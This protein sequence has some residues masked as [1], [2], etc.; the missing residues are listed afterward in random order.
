MEILPLDRSDDAVLEQLWRSTQRSERV[1][2]MSGVRVS[3]A[4]FAEMAR[5]AHPGERDEAVVALVDGRVVGGGRIWFPERDNLTLSWLEVHVDPD[6]RRRGIGSALL[7]DLESR[8]RAAGRSTVLADAFV[9]SGAA[10]EH[11]VRRFARASGYA[12]YSVEIVRELRLPVD[13]ARLE[14]LDAA[15]RPAWEGDY[16]VTVHRNG[17]PE[18]LRPSLCAAMNRLG[19]DAP[20]GEVAFEE[21][22][23]DPEGYADF[24]AHETRL[25]RDRLTAV[26]VQRATGEVVAYSDLAIPAGDPDAV[27]QWG[28]LVLRAHRGHRLG[29]AVKVANL[30]ALAEAW[31][32]R[33]RVQTMNASDNPWMVGI[34]ERLGFRVVEEALGLRRVLPAAPSTQAAERHTVGA[35]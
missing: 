3:L 8:A 13:G 18:P 23:L 4:E 7:A 27:L 6:H 33:R 16:E 32:Q 15:A 25:G 29:T 20:T 19:V 11:P 31:P 9:P 5:Y 22:T 14:G 34:N 28:T 12:V 26:A 21:E 30:R 2:R 10:E 35:C 24:L 1:S 17:V